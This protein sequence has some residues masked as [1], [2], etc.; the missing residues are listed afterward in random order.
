MG[1]QPRGKITSAVTALGSRREVEL[2]TSIEPETDIRLRETYMDLNVSGQDVSLPSQARYE[3]TL[4]VTYL[5]DELMIAR[6]DTGTP[7]V[8]LRRWGR[9]SAGSSSAPDYTW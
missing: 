3:R 2:R 7:D 8:L 9:P 4:Y 5:D 1:E 6:D